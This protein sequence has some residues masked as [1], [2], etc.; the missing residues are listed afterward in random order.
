MGVFETEDVAHDTRGGELQALLESGEAQRGLRKLAVTHAGGRRWVLVGLGK[1]N[2]FDAEHARMAAAAAL[3]RAV[4]LDTTTLCWEVPHH[5][6]EDV[7]G[8]LVE[9]T[10]LRDYRFD[11]YRSGDRDG[12]RRVQRLLVSA[13]HDVAEPVARAAVLAQATNEARDLQNAPA[14]DM[15]PTALGEAARGLASELDGLAVELEGREGIEARGMGSFAAV[16][17][18]S[19]ED[20]RLIVMRYE[21]GGA[22][23]PHLGFVG[24]AVTFDTGGISIK[25]AAK[26][27]EMKFD[28]S[29]G[30]AVIEAVAAIARL[31]LP[32]RVLAVVGATENMPS[33]HAVK[34]GDIVRAMNGTTIE[35][36]N[37]DAEGRMV[38][39]DCLAHAAAE[40]AERLVDLA[41]LTGAVSVALG[42]VNAGL[43]GDDDAWVAE[44][45]A[46]GR[47]AGEPAWR[48][49]LGPEYA[50]MI[51]GRYAD[52]VNSTSE[53][54][55][56]TITA[57]HFLH[58]FT[59]GVPWAHLDIAGVAWDRG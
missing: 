24:K 30:A 55:A 48:L 37:T 7:V 59:G 29:G 51:K 52:I 26:M 49:P 31:R 15:T 56:M 40:G 3:G 47:A 25:P 44:V 5:V 13:H 19:D 46:A 18:G 38:L 10:L 16:A 21:P 43:M 54:K 39:A 57:A 2:E 11:R 35:V 17:R 58:R 36:N 22:T 1:R 50:D 4:E 9:G 20:P 33:G 14:N 45:E 28:M 12:D 53:R 32:V 8:G 41:T 23:G 34:P 42:S 6:G 27:A